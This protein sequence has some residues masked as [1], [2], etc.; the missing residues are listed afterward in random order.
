MPDFVPDLP[1]ILAFAVATVVLAVTPGPDM[2]LQLS[3]AINCGRAHGVAAMC[4][5]MTG[6]LVHTALV[7][8][9]VSV[10]LIAAPPLF[11][12]LKIAGAVYLLWLAWQAVVHGGGLRLAEASRR[13]PTLRQSFAA[14][15]GINLL[16]PKVVL[17][18]VTFLP[19]FVDAHDPAA[20][21][22]L[23][24]LG[25]E[26]VLLSIPLGLA[27]VLAA[28]WLAA[29]F[30]RTRWVERTLNWGFAA[31]FTAFAA[32]ILAAQARQ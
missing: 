20:T 25:A 2:A 32:T 30:K 17:F 11:V 10:L 29:A 15:L 26:F 5:A 14:G 3:R 27:T 1:V 4:G 22:K 7:A 28:G 12:A 16:N 21:G 9:G 6:I 23:F 19:Q 31:I 13:A 18:F 24:F 8:F